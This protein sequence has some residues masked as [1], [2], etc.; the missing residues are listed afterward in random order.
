MIIISYNSINGDV[1]REENK[2]YKADGWIQG[3]I[4]QET[5]L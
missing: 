1:L 2:T 4:H 3:R 5:T